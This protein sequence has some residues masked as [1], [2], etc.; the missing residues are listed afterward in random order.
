MSDIAIRKAT[1]QDLKIIQDLNYQLFVHDSEFESELNMNWP[2]REGENYFKEKITEDTGVCFVVE[3]EGKVVGYLA[4]GIRGEDWLK[5]KRSEIDNMFVAKG[6]RGRGI[7]KALV[8]EFM[9]WSKEQRVK[10]VVVNA[11]WGNED[12]IK[13]YKKVG[14]KNYDQSLQL[15]L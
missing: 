9:K 4:G 7:G 6:F 10:R 5:P 1:V 12:S 3:V 8:K 14:F 13:F 2:Y 11:F 15:E